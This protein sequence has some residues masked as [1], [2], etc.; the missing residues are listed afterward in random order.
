M[1]ELNFGEDELVGMLRDGLDPLSGALVALL[2]GWEMS[3][4]DLGQAYMAWA[5]P[6]SLLSHMLTRQGRQEPGLQELIKSGPRLDKNLDV[7]MKSPTAEGLQ[8][9]A[10]SWMAARAGSQELLHSLDA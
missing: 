8:K 6:A 3:A 5:V 4:E 7:Y 2:D 10:E 1:G 9:V